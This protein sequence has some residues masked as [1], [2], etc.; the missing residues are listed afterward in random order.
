[1]TSTTIRRII[2][3]RQILRQMV[4]QGHATEK[5]RN[6]F[7]IKGD[8]YYRHVSTMTKLGI[9]ARTVEGIV[10]FDLTG[11]TLPTMDL[12][13]NRGASD[14]IVM[15]QHSAKPSDNTLDDKAYD[16][17]QNISRYGAIRLGRVD[18]LDAPHLLMVVFGDGN[19]APFMSA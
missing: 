3:T 10:T 4:E 5:T 15:P 19:D 14:E 7:E 2:T 12:V 11:A 8:L 17:L 16:A 1:M 13:V 9:E 6:V 18:A